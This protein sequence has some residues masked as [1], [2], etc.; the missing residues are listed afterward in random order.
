M[1]FPR[2]QFL[3]VE[4]TRRSRSVMSSSHFGPISVIGRGAGAARWAPPNW[5][6]GRR[7]NSHLH[8]EQFR[9]AHKTCRPLYGRL[10]VQ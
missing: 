4:P 9:S 8:S 6:V 3:H 5:G 10:S 1:A 2:G 7:G